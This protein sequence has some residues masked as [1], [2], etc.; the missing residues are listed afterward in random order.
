MT[1]QK[2]LRMMFDGLSH[3]PVIVVARVKGCTILTG[4][5]N[6]PLSERKMV[7]TVQGIKA[8]CGKHGVDHVSLGRELVRLGKKLKGEPRG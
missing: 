4:L 7:K 8:Q 3:K 2:P 1:K 6:K 5:K